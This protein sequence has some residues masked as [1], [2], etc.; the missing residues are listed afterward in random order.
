[1]LLWLIQETGLLLGS[2]VHSDLSLSC[3]YLSLVS[4]FYIKPGTESMVSMQFVGYSTTD[5]AVGHFSPQERNCY[6]DEEFQPLYF[7][8]VWTLIRVHFNSITKDI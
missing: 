7:N 5:D 4:G 3:K 6:T 1:M 8:K 2:K